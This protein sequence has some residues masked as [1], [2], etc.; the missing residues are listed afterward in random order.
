M[1]SLEP[2]NLYA[3]WLTG[4]RLWTLCKTIIGLSAEHPCNVPNVA[5][6][7]EAANSIR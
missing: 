6:A 7:K 5:T 4:V 3:L 1:I 2:Q